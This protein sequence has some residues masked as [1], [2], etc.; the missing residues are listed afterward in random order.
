MP[1]SIGVPSHT[2]STTWPAISLQSRND[3]YFGKGMHMESTFSNDTLK[4][5]AYLR[6]CSSYEKL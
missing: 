3:I 4:Q 1:C 5:R 6:P 2:A